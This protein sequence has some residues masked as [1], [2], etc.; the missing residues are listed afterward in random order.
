MSATAQVTDA[1]RNTVAAIRREEDAAYEGWNLSNEEAAQLV[2]DSEARAVAGQNAV[3]AEWLNRAATVS[4]ERDQLRAEVDIWK[5]EAKRHH[6]SFCAETL[7]FSEQCQRA[8]RAE[9]ELVEAKNTIGSLSRDRAAAMDELAALLKREEKAEA[10]AERYR[11]VTL[12]QDADL[13]KERARLD[14]ILKLR[15]EDETR[16]DIDHA[17]MEGGT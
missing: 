1:H 10:A 3:I 12:R 8:E 9:A 16:E 5:Q 14:W 4:A 6:D 7:R 2:A 15:C 13:A 11:L 17:M